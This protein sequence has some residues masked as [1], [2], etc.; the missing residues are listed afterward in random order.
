MGFKYVLIPAS[1]T[2]EMQELDYAEDVLDLEKDTFRGFT[3]KYFQGLGGSVDRDILLKCLKEKTGMDLAEKQ[4]KGE[5]DSMAL[6]KLLSSTSCEIFPIML[7]T[8]AVD[9]EG[10][11]AYCD[12]KGVAK[13]LPDNPRANGLARACGFP[14]QSFRGDIFISRIFDDNEDE[15][16]RVDFTLKDCSSEAAWVNKTKGQRSNK[17]SGDIKRLAD[18][19]GATNP[20]HINPST[21]DEGPPKGETAQYAWRQTEDEVEVTFKKD[22]LQKG[23]KKLVKVTFSRQKLKVE[24]KG[25]VLIDAQLCQATQPDEATWTL[26]D[27][28][29]QVTLSKAEAESWPQLLKE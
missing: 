1:A 12:D 8:K 16:R 29:L 15:W 21:M 7:P 17:S 3:E 20:A 5:M 4:A 23:D 18:Q 28:V 22:G 26:S 27:S 9:F 19:V 14:G 2:D 11:S 24:V 25:E 13:E 6:D 10:V